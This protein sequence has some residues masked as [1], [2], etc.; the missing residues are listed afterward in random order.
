[1]SLLATVNGRGTLAARP[2]AAAANEGYIYWATD[3]TPPTWY[4]SNGTSWDAQATS[5]LA[6]Q[7]TFT[8]L[9]GTVAAAPATPAAGKLRMYAKTGKVL[10]VK[11]DAGV[12]TV[13]GAGGGGG[14]LVFLAAQ[15]ASASATLDFT[16]F[17]SSTYDDY[18]FRF[19]G[20][21]PA[22]DLVD[23]YM[24]VSVAGVFDTGANYVN[25]HYLQATSGNVSAVGTAD[26]TFAVRRGAEITNAA[27]RGLSGQIDLFNPQSTTL[28]K[29]I[30]GS[31]SW[32]GATNYINSIMDGSWKTAAS[33]VDGVRFLFSAG[34]IASGT[35]RVYGVTKS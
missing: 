10:A 28:E 6:D 8:Y 24:Q 11:D 21:V 18:V 31:I 20:V 1:M 19:I 34:N 32:S 30:R 3:S 12:E 9:D 16:T 35:I 22:T 15:T 14:A 5:G 7:G 17:I 29:R 23:F 26:T 13:L 25:N 2:A 27:A 4:R 33:A